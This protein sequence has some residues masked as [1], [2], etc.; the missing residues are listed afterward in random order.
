MSFLN[1][2]AILGTGNVQISLHSGWMSPSHNHFRMTWNIH[3]EVSPGQHVAK[4]S[5]PSFVVFN[6]HLHLYPKFGALFP[7]TGFPETCVTQLVPFLPYFTSHGTV[8][9]QDAEH[10]FIAIVEGKHVPSL[11]T[12]LHWNTC[13]L[14][15]SILALS[16]A[17]T[18]LWLLKAI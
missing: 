5:N 7:C 12:I 11:L 4:V 15:K 6:I 9:S 8:H 14:Y 17:L 16:S 18:V 10:L 1:L 2:G 3:E 13:N